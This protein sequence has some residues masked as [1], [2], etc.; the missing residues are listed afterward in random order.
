MDDFVEEVELA[1]REWAR[2]HGGSEIRWNAVWRQRMAR[3][4]RQQQARGR[5]VPDLAWELGIRV[6]QLRGWLY[7]RAPWQP[8]AEEA[9]K[10]PL[11]PVQVVGETV[12]ISDGV[13]ERRYAVR[14]RVGVVVRDLTLSDLTEVLRSLV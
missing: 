11:R 10:A 2:L 6:T 4:A 5:L 3:W 8:P 7:A 9:D 1:R 12:R 13:P 14:L